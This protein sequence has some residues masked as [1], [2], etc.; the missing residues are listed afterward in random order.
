MNQALAYF[1]QLKSSDTGWQLASSTLVNPALRATLSDHVKFFSLQIVEA[2]VKHSYAKSDHAQQQSMRSFLSQWIQ[3]QVFQSVSAVLVLV[4]K[5]RI[6][7]VSQPVQEKIFIR[8]KAAQVFALVFV[9]DYPDRWPTFFADLLQTLSLGSRTVDHY[10]RVLL[11][12]DLEVVDREVMH[13]KEVADRN[14][15]IKD[16]MRESCVPDLVDS[17]YH[18]MVICIEAYFLFQLMLTCVMFQT[19]CEKTDADL[20][21]QTLEVVGA[22]ISWINISLIANLRFVD[23]LVRFLREATLR[24]AAADCLHD[25][26]AKGMDPVAKTKLVESLLSVLDSAGILNIEQVCSLC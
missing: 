1:E 5:L 12:V 14:T 2:F 24:E 25:I 22:Y 21:C 3:L 10:L 23:L 11:A 26:V 7:Q 19:A 8:N 9:N 16:H 17:W 6:L 18:I 15:R 4:L 13:S 20:V